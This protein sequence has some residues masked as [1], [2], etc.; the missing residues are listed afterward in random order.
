MDM[1][2]HWGVLRHLRQ[3]VGANPAILI[4]AL[5]MDAA[6]LGAL[7]VTKGGSDPLVLIVSAVGFVL[8]FG[9]EYLFLYRRGQAD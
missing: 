7:L 6:V 3:D 9:G 8:I 5:V 1:A 2:V 4:A